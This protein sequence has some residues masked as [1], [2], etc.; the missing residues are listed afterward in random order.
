MEALSGQEVERMHCERAPPASPLLA[1]LLALPCLSAR[2]PRLHF[3][4]GEICRRATLEPPLPPPPISSTFLFII[5]ITTF[6]FD[7]EQQRP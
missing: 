1:C 5:S 3:V 6:I 2:L 7:Q 4:A